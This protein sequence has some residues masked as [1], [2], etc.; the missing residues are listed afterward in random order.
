MA[1]KENDN[2]KKLLLEFISSIEDEKVIK[3]IHDFLDSDSFAEKL[4]DQLGLMPVWVV[5][6]IHIS[7]SLNRIVTG[8]GYASREKLRVM[9]YMFS[10]AAPN[11]IV[12]HEVALIFVDKN[13][14][15]VYYRTSK[16]N[17]GYYN[18]SRWYK[19]ENEANEN[20]GTYESVNKVPIE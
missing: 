10:K 12:P 20:I 17:L 7:A 14:E 15:Y 19:S 8:I 2:L 18:Y 9:E 1:T 4:K 6:E 16:N 5:Y 13:S 3:A 11:R